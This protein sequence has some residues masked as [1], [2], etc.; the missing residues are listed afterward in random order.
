MIF[1]TRRDLGPIVDLDAETVKSL[2]DVFDRFQNGGSFRVV[3]INRNDD[4]L[5]R[6]E[7]RR[8]DQ[9]VMSSFEK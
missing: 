8:K 5:I 2:P 9:P 7:P 6:G 4:D 3:F 1:I